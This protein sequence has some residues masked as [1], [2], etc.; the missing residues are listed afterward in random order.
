MGLK[1]NPTRPA[2]PDPEG[3]PEGEIVNPNDFLEHSSLVVVAKDGAET[4]NQHFPGH[5]WAIQINAKGRVFHVFN[6]ALHDQWGYLIRADEVIHQ[7]SIRRVF[8]KAGGEI[9]ERFGLKRGRLDPMA[10]AALPKDLK[11]RCIPIIN[12]LEIAAA[13]K[14]MR[15]RRIVEAIKAGMIHQDSSGRVLVAVH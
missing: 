5:L 14:E 1:W 13:K 4:L 15:K 8:L 12:D 2:R 9:L 3:A 11:G 6:H 10:Y 7:G